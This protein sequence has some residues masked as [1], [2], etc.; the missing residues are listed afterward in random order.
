MPVV[1]AKSA[2]SVPVIL[3]TIL[4][5]GPVPVLLKVR[6]SAALAIPVSVVGS[7][8]G[9]GLSETAGAVPVPVKP[10]ICG[11]GN[12]LSATLTDAVRV[13]VA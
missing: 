2:E 8:S 7:V 10:A 3:E 13:P 1:M 6:D 9:L 11:V 5:N 4:V 12:A